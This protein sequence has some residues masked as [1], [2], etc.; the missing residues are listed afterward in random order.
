M[1]RLLALLSF[2]T[3]SHAQNATLLLVNAKIWTANSAQPEAE[4]VAVSGNR[5]I[6]VGSYNAILKLKQDKTAVIDLAGRRLVPG[7]NDAH[8]HFYAGGASLAG[9]QL[10]YS[11]SRMEFRDT[12]AEFARKT[13]KGQWITGGEWDEENWQ[14]AILPTHELIDGVTKEW[15]VFI[16]RLDGHESLANIVALKLAGIDRSTKDVP[17]GVIVRDAHGDPTG[18]LK[19]AAQELVNRVIPPPTPDQIRAAIRAAQVY[20]NAQGVTSVQDMS[21]APEVFRVYQAMMHDGD[22]T[23]RI[24]GHQPLV[25]WKRLADAGVQADFGSEQIHIGA[26]KGFADGSL[27]SRTA[28]FF[29]P[30]LDAPGTNGIPSAELASPSEMLAH[31]EAADAAGLQVAVHAIGDKANNTILNFYEQVEKEHGVRD[32][33]FRIEHAQHLLA[34]DIPRFAKLHVI[35]SVQPYHCIDDGRWAEK[36]IGPERAKT[37]YAFRSLLD[38]GATLA[39][40]SDWDVAPMK[41]ILGIYAAVTRRTLDGKHPEGWVPEQ[42]ITVEDAMKAYTMGSAYASFDEKVKGSIEP[43][44]LADMV[45]LT[46]DIFSIDPAKIADV[47]VYETIFDGYFVYGPKCGMDASGFL[48][49]SQAP[50]CDG[51]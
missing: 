19:D 22:L 21:A 38:S 27:G 43:G 30:Y 36:R 20:A 40:G 42:K 11:K 31:I 28:L 46:D 24:S 39:F 34:T 33:R 16:N 47:K 6:A 5:I 1:R 23:V 18:V 15:P 35:A 51:R 29:Q 25:S 4:A 13:P 7:F 45:V 8:V 17:G 50:G 3:L 41:P 44:K 37:T 2:C 48:L 32:R 10:R 9:P 14:P 26:L 12:L 49:R